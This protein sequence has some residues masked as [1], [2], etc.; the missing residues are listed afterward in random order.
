MLD[1]SLKRAELGTAIIGTSGAPQ[2]VFWGQMPVSATTTA[3]GH[4][5]GV[6]ATNQSDR[7]ALPRG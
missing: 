4:R 1:Q 6:A 7:G 5:N 3:T 2:L